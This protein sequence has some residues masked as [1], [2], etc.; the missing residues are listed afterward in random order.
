MAINGVFPTLS[1]P[2]QPNAGNVLSEQSKLTPEPGEKTQTQN[3]VAPTEKGG[4]EFDNGLSAGN[5][6][7]RGQFVDVKV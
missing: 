6:D 5:K 1:S 7:G 3:A 4:G 2:V